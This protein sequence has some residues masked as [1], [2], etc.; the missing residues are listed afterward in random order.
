VARSCG[1][2]ETFMRTEVCLAVFHDRGLIRVERATD[3]LRIQIRDTAGKVD[4]E[5]SELMRQL[6][7]LAD[8]S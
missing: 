1:L 7:R 6:R 5:S 8:R 2:R 4:L 3:H